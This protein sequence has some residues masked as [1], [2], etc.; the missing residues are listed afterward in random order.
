MTTP[1]K[2]VAATLTS[3]LENPIMASILDKSHDIDETINEV[4]SWWRYD[5]ASRKPGIAYTSG[6]DKTT[7]LDLSCFLFELAERNAVINIPIY[8]SIRA[9]SIKEGEFVLS[10]QNRHGNVLGLSANKDVFSFSL[11]IKDMNAV[12][13]DNVGAF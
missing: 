1:K 12:S 9:K 8:K 2:K 7:D 4:V 6:G 3:I 10:S 5:M 11:R 13:T